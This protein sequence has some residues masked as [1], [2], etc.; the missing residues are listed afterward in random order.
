M[1]IRSDIKKFI[2]YTEHSKTCGNCIHSEESSS[3]F[4]LRCENFNI[5]TSLAVT[6]EGTCNFF[7]SESTD[8]R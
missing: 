1:G 8:G 6:R 5:L 2:E 7:K 4:L 3:T